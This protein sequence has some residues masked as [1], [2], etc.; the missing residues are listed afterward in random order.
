VS[1]TYA[2]ASSVAG[3]RAQTM[4]AFSST[5]PAMV[6]L[7][8]NRLQLGEIGGGHMSPVGAYDNRTDRFLILDVSRYKYPPVWVTATALFASMNTTDSDAGKSRGWVVVSVPK[9]LSALPPLPV[10]PALN[11]TSI[12]AC[13]ASLTVDDPNA[14]AACFAGGAPVPPPPPP[15]P[16]LK[17]CPAAPSCGGGSGALSTIT[18]ASHAACCTALPCVLLAAGGSACT[19]GSPSSPGLAARHRCIWR[20]RRF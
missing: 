15:S 6:G 18:S 3:L 4:A 9:T 2:S 10:T 19:F 14:I 5:P 11:N 20:L 16:P 7:N 13:I 8:F 1:A 17:S 12:Q